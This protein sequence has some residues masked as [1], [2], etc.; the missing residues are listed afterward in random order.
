MEHISAQ[1]LHWWDLIR[2]GKDHQLETRTDRPD[3]YIDLNEVD[4][5]ENGTV[6]LRTTAAEIVMFEVGTTTYETQP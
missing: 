2:L 3:R 4:A 1:S 6:W 5:V